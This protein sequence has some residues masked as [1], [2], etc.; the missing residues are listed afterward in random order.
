MT[1]DIFYWYSLVV[2]SLAGGGLIGLIPLLVG[3]KSGKRS[4]GIAG[5]LCCIVGSFILGLFLSLPCCIGCPYARTAVSGT[6]LEPKSWAGG[7]PMVPAGNARKSAGMPMAW[8]K[9]TF[10][11]AGTYQF[12]A[13]K[14]VNCAKLLDKAE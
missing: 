8:S 3:E 9:W 2:G 4:L 12:R 13:A 6:I 1:E 11:R 14:Y 10:L 7:M 5:F